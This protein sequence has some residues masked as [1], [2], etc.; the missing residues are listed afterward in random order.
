MNTDN[1]AFT[2]LRPAPRTP[3]PLTRC[4]PP[5]HR[6]TT[7]LEW[8]SSAPSTATTSTPATTTTVTT[9]TYTLVPLSHRLGPRQPVPSS[10][11][12]SD[13]P[14][15][16]TPTQAHEPTPFTQ[17]QSSTAAASR[18]TPTCWNCG[19]RDH[20]YWTC[21]NPLKPHLAARNASANWGPILHRAICRCP[22]I[23]HTYCVCN[24]WGACEYDCKFGPETN[25]G[26]LLSSLI[27]L[28]NDCY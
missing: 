10:P 19:K 5:P 26:V 1:P 11:T 3:R 25:C 24:H 14:H 17:S 23:H 16:T 13:T 12:P 22:P 7:L 6:T 21:P 9:T 18:P 2:P 27:R 8:I 28:R 4:I 20:K 15:A